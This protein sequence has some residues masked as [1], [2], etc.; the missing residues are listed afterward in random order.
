MTRAR[1][2]DDKLRR[3]IELIHKEYSTKRLNRILKRET[4]RGLGSS[5]V[6]DLRLALKG[7][8][9]PD[10]SGKEPSGKWQSEILRV[11]S[12]TDFA[13]APKIETGREPP[14]LPVKRYS[15]V[16]R[17]ANKRTLSPMDEILGAAMRL[18]SKVSVKMEGNRV[19][20]MEITR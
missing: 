19:V 4:G 15:G 2:F 6:S 13:Y 10:R 8:A 12:A 17:Q 18:N 1:N 3:A 14:P 7:K 5:V 9:L 11:V 20:S 16:L